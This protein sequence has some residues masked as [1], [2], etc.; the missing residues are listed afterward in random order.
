MKEIQKYN[1][2]KTASAPSVSI[3]Y[4]FVFSVENDAIHIHEGTI[5]CYSKTNGEGND[6]ECNPMVLPVSIANYP[7]YARRFCALMIDKKAKD[8][9]RMNQIT[10]FHDNQHKLKMARRKA[11]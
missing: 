5:A 8:D 11:V 7:V 6:H 9:H 3:T 1:F 10:K 2:Q 4:S